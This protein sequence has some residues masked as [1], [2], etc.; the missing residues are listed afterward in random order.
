MITIP[1]KLLSRK[2]E[3][4]TEFFNLLDQH[5]DDIING[6]INY[7]FRIKDFAEQLSLNASHLS[8]VVKLVAKRSPLDFLEE[9]LVAEG[10]IMLR[11]TNLTI[12]EIAQ[13]LCFRDTK[14]FEK[15]F[16]R[17]SRKRLQSV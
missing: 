2:H 8:N 11:E 7:V 13:K 5:I 15:L 6:R 17:V 16:T 9:R 14:T 10:E 1:Q 12:S 3:I 4:A